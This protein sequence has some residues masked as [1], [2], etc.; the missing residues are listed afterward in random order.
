MPHCVLIVEDHVVAQIGVG[1]LL[2][3]FGFEVAGAALNGSE[4]LE[5][6]QGDAPDMVLLDVQLPQED[7][8]SVL[9]KIGECRPELPVVVW[10]A[11]DNPTYVARAAAL[12]ACDYILKG[13]E[14][15]ILEQAVQSAVNGQT[16]SPSS[17]LTKVRRMMSEEI[18][19]NAL[20]DGFPL[21]SREA[22]VLRHIALGLSNKEIAKSLKISVET[23]K[24]HVQNILRKTN[25]TDRTAA[26]V[27]AI[28]SG[29]VD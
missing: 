6:V 12:G 22:Q 5:F 20:P 16:A 11:Y 14:A 27:R 13:G 25:A 3:S 28:K 29:L 8:F 19:V 10:S 7:G 17:L 9:A 26:A 23:V 15:T 21:T 1:Q 18:D 4:A 2:R 24:E